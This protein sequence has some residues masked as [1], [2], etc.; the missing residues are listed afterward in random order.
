MYISLYGGNLTYTV[1]WAIHNEISVV[2]VVDNAS[3][4]RD[5]AENTRCT[6]TLEQGRHK[7]YM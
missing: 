7:R 1:V 3:V 5:C 2:M 6:V 4:P